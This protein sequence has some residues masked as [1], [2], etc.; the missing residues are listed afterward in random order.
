MAQHRVQRA[1]LSEAQVLREPFVQRDVFSREPPARK[2]QLSWAHIDASQ[3]V[4]LGEAG[5]AQF[6][7]KAAPA[8]EV[9]NASMARRINHIAKPLIGRVP[10]RVFAFCRA[11]FGEPGIAAMNLKKMFP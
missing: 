5:A 3:G 10:S 4:H 9:E 1:S 8:G 11:A 2:R 7:K 6:E